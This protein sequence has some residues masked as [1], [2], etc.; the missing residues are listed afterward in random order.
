MFHKTILHTL[1]YTG[2]PITVANIYL[3]INLVPEFG[4]FKGSLQHKIQYDI[5]NCEWCAWSYCTVFRHS[6]LSR[7]P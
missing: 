1:G 2:L 6:D 3:F 5:V 4:S 7:D